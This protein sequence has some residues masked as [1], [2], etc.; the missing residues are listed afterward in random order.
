[1]RDSK[2]IMQDAKAQGVTFPTSET[3]KCLDKGLELLY[4]NENVV[5]YFV[6]NSGI[7]ERKY[8]NLLTDKNRLIQCIEEQE[9]YVGLNIFKTHSYMHYACDFN[10]NQL[11][12]EKTSFNVYKQKG[13]F[14]AKYG[15]ITLTFLEGDEEVLGRIRMKESDCETA[16]SVILEHA[17]EYG[18]K[19]EKSE[20]KSEN[21]EKPAGKE[22][23]IKE[24]RAMHD[25]GLITKE[26]MMELLKALMSK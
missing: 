11:L 22:A 10:L 16:Y 25:A 15:E 18:A 9:D 4:L 26:E 3:E 1:M 14:G 7:E 13:L 21:V 5:T 20:S 19:P 6:D 8:I 23:E 17:K 24:I 2:A 12:P